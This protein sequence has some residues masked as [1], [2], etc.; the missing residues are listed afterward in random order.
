MSIELSRTASTGQAGQPEVALAIAALGGAEDG[1]LL[2]DTAELRESWQRIQSSFV[3]DPHGSVTEAAALVDH[4]AQAL[5]G[6][7]R[8]RQLRLRDSLDGEDKSRDTEQLR[9]TMQRYR[10]L[11]NQ[12]CRP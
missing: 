1:P 11:F 8:R 5:S 4:V 7:L 10:S 6:A 12:L 2:P 3:D 9:V